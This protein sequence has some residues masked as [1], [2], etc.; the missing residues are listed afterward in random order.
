ML[1]TKRSARKSNIHRPISYEDLATVKKRKL[2]WYVRL[3]HTIIWPRQKN[4][5]TR[6]MGTGRRR[7]RQKKRW[8][9]TI[10]V[11]RAGACQLP[12]GCGEQKTM[13]RAGCKV[14]SGAPTILTGYG[15][16]EVK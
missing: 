1:P 2:E 13:E 12:Q 3:R 11:D 15:K 16:S 5:L 14:V 8:E 6:Y 4:H 10:K 9:D 7:G